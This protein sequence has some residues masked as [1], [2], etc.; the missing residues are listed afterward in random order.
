MTNLNHSFTKSHVLGIIVTLFFM[1]YYPIMDAEAQQLRVLGNL[2]E[3]HENVN[4]GE[5]ITGNVYVENRSDERRE[6]MIYLEASDKAGDRDVVPHASFSPEILMVD[7]NTREAVQYEIQVPSDI[8][9]TMWGFLVVREV[10]EGSVFHTATDDEIRMT[11]NLEYGIHL[12]TTSRPDNRSIDFRDM[13]LEDGVLT[14]DTFNDGNTMYRPDVHLRV[15]NSDGDRLEDVKGKNYL[16]YPGT[17]LT[18]EFDLSELD[19][20]NYSLQLVVNIGG[21][22]NTF[23]VPFDVEL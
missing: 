22:G 14:V 2:I 19:S 17:T 20:G 18:Q 10:R 8:D 21:R 4:P 1:A 5:T 7:P 6:V 15:F 3:H 23:A 12:I 9:G 11:H 13:S 16:H